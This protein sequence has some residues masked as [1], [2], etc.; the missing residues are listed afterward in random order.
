L[1]IKKTSRN[2]GVFIAQLGGLILVKAAASL[3]PRKFGLVSSL[4]L[5]PASGGFHFFVAAR[6]PIRAAVGP[7]QREWIGLEITPILLHR[8]GSIALAT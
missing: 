5:G 1:E 7:T 6:F 2:P 3:K 8:S 4:E